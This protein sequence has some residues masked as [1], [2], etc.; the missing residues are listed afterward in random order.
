MADRAVV[1]S[2]NEPVSCKDCTFC[3]FGEGNAA[4]VVSQ[5]RKISEAVAEKKTA[6]A[7]GHSSRFGLGCVGILSEKKIKVAVGIEVPGDC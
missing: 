3:V 4:L 2:D 1:N 7:A 6:Q 5:C